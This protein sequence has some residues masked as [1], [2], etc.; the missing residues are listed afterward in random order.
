MPAFF[1]KVKQRVKNRDTYKEFLKVLNL[2]S[3]EM[4][5]QAEMLRLAEDILGKYP[6]LFNTL[7]S[8]VQTEENYG[9]TKQ[10]GIG[11]TNKLINYDK[12]KKN[13]SR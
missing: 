2:Y 12:K 9:K 3:Q 6:D 10:G 11:Q 8:I 5:S 1:E 4:V 7:K 13:F